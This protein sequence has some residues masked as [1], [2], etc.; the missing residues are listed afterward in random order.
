MRI[1]HGFHDICGIASTLSQA[2]RA[3]G[4]TSQCIV[5]NAPRWGAALHPENLVDLNLSGRTVTYKREARANLLK[6]LL[7]DPPDRLVVHFNDSVM[8]VTVMER[9]RSN[10]V[11]DVTMDQRLVDAQ[12]NDLWLLKQKGVEILAVFHGCDVRR[13]GGDRVCDFCTYEACEVEDATRFFRQIALQGVA[14]TLYVTTPDLLRWVPN[15]KLLPQAVPDV[16]TLRRTRPKDRAEVR[17]I[18]CPSSPEKKGTRYIREAVER[19]Q[20][21]VDFDFVECSD[22]SRS[23]LLDQ[24]AKCDLLIDQGVMGWYGTVAAEA[25][26]LGIPVLCYI[27]PSAVRYAAQLDERALVE[28]MFTTGA[29]RR[30]YLPEV[31]PAHRLRGDAG[32]TLEDQ[33]RLMLSPYWLR[34]EPRLHWQRFHSPAAVLRRMHPEFATA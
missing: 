18:H 7:A 4:A 14:E 29:I 15:A 12:M 13:K 8:S 5:W 3:A 26:C 32:N 21:E 33:L 1:V 31:Y 17:V 6:A 30:F 34:G 10:G 2:E 20:E 25:M 9:E 11:D 27:D 19:A 24:I 22:M 23:D 16:A 28:S